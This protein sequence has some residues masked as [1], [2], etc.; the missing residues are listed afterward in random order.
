MK[1]G[2]RGWLSPSHF[3]ETRGGHVLR[4]EN[5]HPR[6]FRY[7]PT[8]NKGPGWPCPHPRGGLN[9][10]VSGNPVPTCQRVL[11][12]GPK[13]DLPPHRSQAARGWTFSDLGCHPVLSLWLHRQRGCCWAEATPTVTL[14][15]PEAWKR[16]DTQAKVP[17]DDS[18]KALGVRVLWA[19]RVHVTCIDA[20]GQAVSGPPRGRE[21]GG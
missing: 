13:T 11:S 20:E 15:A 21:G 3:S 1:S 17:W 2:L 10:S 12:P 6:K 5:C 4:N 8:L 7:K 18:T 19:A 9:G 14:C 16:R